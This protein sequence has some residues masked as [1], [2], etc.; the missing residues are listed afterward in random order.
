MEIEWEKSVGKWTSTRGFEVVW[1][2]VRA[3]D[4]EWQVRLHGTSQ[5]ARWEGGTLRYWMRLEWKLE[6]K[7][8][9]SGRNNARRTQLIKQVFDE[10]QQRDGHDRVEKWYHHSWDYHL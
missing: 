8:S 6:A 9:G 10:A 3:K 1:M 7:R 4:Q 2:G 5:E